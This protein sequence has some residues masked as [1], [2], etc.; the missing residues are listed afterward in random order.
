MSER[1]AIVRERRR[2]ARERC[3][4]AIPSSPADAAAV[5]VP[6]PD[7]QACCPPQVPIFFLISFRPAQVHD[8][9]TDEEVT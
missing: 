3:A 1:R 7:G 2:I 8:A 5:T 4:I 6:Q 9:R